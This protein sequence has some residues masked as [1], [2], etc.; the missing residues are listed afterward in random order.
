M[1]VNTIRL[2]SHLRSVFKEKSENRRL[3]GSKGG[4]SANEDM[5][6]VGTRA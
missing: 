3:N 4:P 1:V 6:C 5:Q 2:A